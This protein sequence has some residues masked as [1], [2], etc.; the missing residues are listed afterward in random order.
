MLAVQGWCVANCMGQSGGTEQSTMHM[1]TTHTLGIGYEGAVSRLATDPG[2][3][4]P[5]QPTQCIL[6]SPQH[7]SQFPRGSTCVPSVR[8]EVSLNA[9][10]KLGT[11]TNRTISMHA[12]LLK[13]AAFLC[14]PTN[15]ASR[16]SDPAAAQQA[17]MQHF[18]PRMR[19][20]RQLDTLHT[21]L[22]CY[23]RCC[24]CCCCSLRTRRAT[25]SWLVPSRV[26][27]CC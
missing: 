9:L 21:N 16:P 22:L 13:L 25:A 15:E 23:L 2:K 6:L 11:S 4:A 18:L 19:P 10:H 12:D 8:H 14:L 24:C 26:H 5:P 7:A 17:G 3:V 27:C 1:V 20:C